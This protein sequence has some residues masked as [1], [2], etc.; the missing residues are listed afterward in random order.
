MWQMEN[1]RLDEKFRL[2]CETESAYVLS[3]VYTIKV[4]LVKV[5]QRKL[6][7][8][9]LGQVQLFTLSKLFDGLVQE[10]TGNAL[11]SIK[12]VNISH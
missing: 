1:I 6:G 5:L 2:S 12:Y 3:C 11:K 9:F 10:I 7:Q 8:S 4:F